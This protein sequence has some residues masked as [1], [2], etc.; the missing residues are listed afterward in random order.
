MVQSVA[1]VILLCSKCSRC[2]YFIMTKLKSC[3]FGS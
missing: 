3:F 1:V 2:G